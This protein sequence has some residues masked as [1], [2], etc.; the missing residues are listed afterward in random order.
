MSDI[1]NKKL[2]LSLNASWQIIGTRT[3]REAIVFLC[4]ESN[5]SPPGYALDIEMDG[6]DMLF[7]NP[8]P[9]D[10]WVRLPVRPDDLY[11]Q[12]AH[13]KIRAP[14]VVIALNFTKLPFHRPRLSPA[15]VW[16][17]DKGICQY[18]G[19]KLTRKEGNIDHVIPR[20]RGGR[21]TWENV[22]LAD[23]SI[24]SA[25]GNRLN[26]EVG[27]KLIRQPKAPP[28]IPVSAMITQA[29]HPTWLPFLVR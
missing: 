6:N 20:D 14:T 18:S 22:A 19:R 13:Q 28:S 23:R 9:W 4:S 5:G 1:L 2:T 11:V 25:K 26:S 3:I 16:E 27:L 7:A 21:D 8:V 15:A 12:T 10:Q 29:E 24:N 17:R